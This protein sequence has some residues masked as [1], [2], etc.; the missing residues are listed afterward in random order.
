[1]SS[2]TSQVEY[3]II[4]GAHPEMKAIYV[5]QENID[6]CS[7]NGLTFTKITHGFVFVPGMK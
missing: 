5:N 6:W 7:G 3:H 1:M 4:D 2:E